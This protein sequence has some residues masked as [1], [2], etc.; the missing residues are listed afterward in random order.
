MAEDR[1]VQVSNGSHKI[2]T[3]VLLI[4]STMHHLCATTQYLS[5]V[6]YF[7]VKHNCTIISS[8]VVVFLCIGNCH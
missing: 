4:E 2:Q 8:A 5:H 6:T 7:E 3:P 1:F